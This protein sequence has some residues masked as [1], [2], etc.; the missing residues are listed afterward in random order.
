MLAASLSL[1]MVA[2]N[3]TST[4]DTEKKD[5]TVVAATSTENTPVNNTSTDV[6]APTRTAFEAKYPNASRV[7]WSRYK[8]ETD[9]KDMDPS[10]WEYKLDTNDYTVMFNWNGED[11]YAWYDDSNL[12]RATSRV[13]SSKLPAA[14]NDAINKEFPGYTIKEIDKE[15]DK[16]RTTY[17]IDL[18]KNGEKMKVH[19]DEN[20]KVVKKKGKVDGKK[21]KEKEEKQ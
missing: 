18:D 4:T 7:T 15:N 20:G 17:E 14:V 5:T 10:D 21:V 1:G 16:D 12:I 11:Y 9:R 2:C 8:A 6:P 13:E 19:I 3:D